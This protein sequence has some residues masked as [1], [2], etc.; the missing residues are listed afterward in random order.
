MATVLITGGTGMIGTALTRQLLA[1]GYDV[2]I[3]SRKARPSQTKGLTYAEWDLGKGTIDPNA[4]AA[5]DYIVH[6]AGANVAEGRWT[7][8]RKQE[9]VDSRVQSGELLVKSL[10]ETS[11]RVK[12][13]ISSSATGWYGPDKTIP[14]QKPFMETD[15]SFPDFLGATCAKWEA[16]TAPV[17]A[18][19]KRLVYLRT[20]IVLSTEGGAYVEFLK[21][22]KL[23]VAA[24]LG[25]GKQVISW[26]HIDDL[27]NLY[28]TAIENESWTGAYNAVAPNPVDNRTLIRTMAEVRGKFHITAPVPTFVLKA[29][30]GEMSVEVLKSTTVS[31]QKALDQGFVF[32]YPD[33]R[34]ATRALAAVAS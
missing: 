4:L 7:D 14:S 20:G 10:K 23:G 11:N 15:P 21:P 5:A 9:I 28:I 6:L 22:L 16:A 1:K 2:I 29:M 8:K 19:G 32:R 33:A 27:V 34:S 31:A 25:S 30:L 24:V 18:M 26:I 13:L 3:L 17:A 12:A